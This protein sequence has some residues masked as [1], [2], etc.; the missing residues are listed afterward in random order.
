MTLWMKYVLDL[1]DIE[2]VNEVI[3]HIAYLIEKLDIARGSKNFWT[4]E[5][6]KLVLRVRTDCKIIYSRKLIASKE[7]RKKRRVLRR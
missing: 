6:K 5:L 2:R 1:R 4:E 3:T 7:K